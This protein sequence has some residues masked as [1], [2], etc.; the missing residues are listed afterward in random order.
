M[1]DE[2][3]TLEPRLTF[4]LDTETYR[5]FNV[6]RLE[7]IFKNFYIQ[8]ILFGSKKDLTILSE[9]LWISNSEKWYDN[10]SNR[11]CYGTFKKKYILVPHLYKTVENYY[12]YGDKI[13][14][15]GCG[16]GILVEEILRKLTNE[17]YGSELFKDSVD[18]LKLKFPSIKSHFYTNNVA[19]ES[20]VGDTAKYDIV[21]GSM[22]LSNI[23][24]ENRALKNLVRKLKKGGYL[25]VADLNPY[26]YKALGYYYENELVPLHNPNSQ[27]FT[28]K[29]IDG[30]TVAVHAYRPWGLYKELLQG[31]KMCLVND[32]VLSVDARLMKKAL[33]KSRIPKKYADEFWK[34]SR[35][36]RPTPPFYILVMRK[37]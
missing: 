16:D 4:T 19:G 22:L 18:R 21:I 6:T 5:K 29:R 11:Y 17:V 1:V 27:F 24:D 14:D 28:E 35:K 34:K 26:Y 7:P 30:L 37:F 25:I 3:L 2:M 20:T 36:I 31:Y 13:L 10:M 33:R 15:V 9:Y 12:S 23:I 8:P 32:Y